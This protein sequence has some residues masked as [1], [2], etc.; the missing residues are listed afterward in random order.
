MARRDTGTDDPR[1]R[2]RPGRGSRPRTKQRPA[3]ADAHLGMVTRIDRGHYRI[4][5]EERGLTLDGSGDVTAMKARELGRGK[6]VVGDRVAVVGDVSG[7]AGS[8]ARMVRVEE[9]RTLLR[10]STEDGEAAGSERPV[11][12]NADLLVVVVSVARPQPRPRMI[13]RYLVA[14]YEADME[15]LLVLTKTDLADP[16]PLLDTYH[17]LGL[18]TLTTHL[19]PDG[20][21]GAVRQALAGRVSV[22]AGHSG[23]GKSTLVNALVPGAGRA[24][25]DVNEV[26]GR[27]RHTSTSLQALEL[28]GGGWVIDTPGVRSFGVSHVEADD[29]LR[30]F[31]D[32][33]AAAQ[34]CPRGCTHLEGARDCA[35]DT[36][37]SQEPTA[38][39]LPPAC[40]EVP[41]P[42]TAVQRRFRVGSFRRLLVPSLQAQDP[43]R[44]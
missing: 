21:V 11:V 1:V 44:S 13:D 4:R 9:R 31:P 6:V 25:G 20:G 16:S 40:D 23:V 17:P 14:A 22:L 26:T 12:A 30:A 33:A 34:Q 35:L 15:P 10:R 27:G 7:R 8:L 29:L 36:W 18:T 41:K 43:T 2:V 39:A 3:H 38:S 28:P 42:A 5:L 37:A 32:L 19:Y 24:T